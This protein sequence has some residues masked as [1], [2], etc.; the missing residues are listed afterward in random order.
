MDETD[1]PRV[2]IVN[3]INKAIPGEKHLPGMRYCGPGTRLEEKLDGEGNPLPGCEP[4]NRVD[5][6]AMYHDKAY[7]QW[8]D[9]RHR[10][11]ADC[12]MVR[13]LLSIERPTCWERLCRCI[14]LPIMCIK[15]VVTAGMLRIS[16]CIYGRE[17]VAE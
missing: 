9:K 1:A 6:A 17:E 4:T 11:Q 15:I 7:A 14:V 5:E 2:D 10:L 16:E 12:T 8:D 3:I 13:A